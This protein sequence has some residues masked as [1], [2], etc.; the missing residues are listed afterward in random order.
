MNPVCG[1][2]VLRRRFASKGREI[3]RNLS[4]RNSVRSFI[5]VITVMMYAIP[6]LSFEGPL[7]VRNQYPIFIHADQQFLEKAS[8][9]NSFSL[10][11]S[12]SSTYTVQ[13][14]SDWIIHLDME[15]TELNLRYRRI[16][17][18]ALEFNLDVPVLVMGGGVFDPFLEDYHST[19]GFSDY[20]RKNRPN[21]EFLYEVRRDGALIVE[22]HS[23]V[24]FGDVRLALK[25]P[26]FQ[27]ERVTISARGD[28]EIPV[29]SAKRGYSNGSLDAGASLLADLTVTD[30][31]AT[32]W[33]AGFVITGDVRGH[34]TLGIKNFIHGGMGMEFTVS[35][36]FSLLTQL[37]GQSAIYP[38]TDLL[39]VDRDAYLLVIGGR[40]RTDAHTIDL[41]LSEDINTSGAPDFILN[42]T[43]KMTL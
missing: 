17:R 33:N 19:F 29:S 24:R 12:H 23:G 26:L 11:L 18:D 38:E 13:E 8:I 4:M 22:G 42:L 1:M 6:A 21:N 20:G 5:L 14:S 35:E 41:S 15:I 16:V 39:A 43:Y 40:Y 10:S 3:E 28:V 34:E 27:S 32:Y 9:E 7:Q 37:Q 2:T 36:R 30:R 31:I 25:R